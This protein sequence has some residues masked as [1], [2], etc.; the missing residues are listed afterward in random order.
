MIHLVSF[1]LV[2]ERPWWDLGLSA[3]TQ[4]Y[5]A[6]LTCMHVCVQ[7]GDLSKLVDAMGQS[8]FGQR[9]RKLSAGL[10]ETVEDFGLVHFTP[11][12]IEVREAALQAH[13]A[14]DFATS[15]CV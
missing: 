11:L 12:A 5:C 3:P 6:F 13:V 2:Y 7:V 9:H 10:A 15:I 4:L 1:W 8:P 14:S